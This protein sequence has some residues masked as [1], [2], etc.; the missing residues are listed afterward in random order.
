MIFSLI[1]AS[2]WLYKIDSSL[3]SRKTLIIASVNKEPLHS[4]II[5]SE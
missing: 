3:A 5:V 4:L 2:F 1:G